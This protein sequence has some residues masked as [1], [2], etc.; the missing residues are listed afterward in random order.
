MK[1]MAALL[2]LLMVVFLMPTAYADIHTHYNGNPNYPMVIFHQGHVLYV[3]KTSISV[4]LYEP[5]KY[6]L[7]IAEF[8][9]PDDGNGPVTNYHSIVFDYDYDNTR[10]YFNDN[11][12]LE[13]L[14]PLFESGRPNYKL[15]RA[16]EAAF[17]LEYGIKFYGRYT[18]MSE[19][20]GEYESDLPNEFYD[21]LRNE[22]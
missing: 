6:R 8:Y 18:W 20:T 11:G 12:T 5:P 10:M 3:D 7:A 17:Y 4:Q 16:G 19:N 21:V 13:Y 1:K 22:R 2:T 15:M 9:A 14:D